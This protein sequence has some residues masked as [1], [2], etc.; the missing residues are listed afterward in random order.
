MRRT[1]EKSSS[2]STG[3]AGEESRCCD[4]VVV[5]GGRCSRSG[6]CF[7]VLLASW[8]QPRAG[9]VMGCGSL[10]PASNERRVSTYL[11]RAAHRNAKLGMS[12]RSWG[13][14]FLLEKFENIESR[15]KCTG[16]ERGA[17]V[18]LP[19]N[20]FRSRGRGC[21]DIG[22]D[23]GILCWGQPRLGRSGVSRKISETYTIYTRPRQVQLRRPSPL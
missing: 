16:D 4:K 22:R 7:G 21:P 6:F 14:G 12:K 17:V 3:E 1:R 8:R 20:R 5:D 19:G 10:L 18:M 2:S 15:G 13:R 23:T 9:D 11:S